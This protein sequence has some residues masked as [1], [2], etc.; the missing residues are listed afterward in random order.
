MLRLAPGSRIFMA[1]KPVD[2]RRSFDGLCATIT[3]AL[4]GAHH[5]E[6]AV[7]RMGEIFQD[8][9]ITLA[10]VNRLV[11]HATIF[12]MNVGSYRRRERSLARNPVPAGPPTTQRPRMSDR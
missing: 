9:A 11:H 2:M 4:G 5:R 7:R 1:V 12:E 10:A 3:E 6:S 8:P